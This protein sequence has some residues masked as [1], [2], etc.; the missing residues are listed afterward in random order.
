MVFKYGAYE[1]NLIYDDLGQVSRD[2]M[3]SF[4]ASV[5]VRGVQ[6]Y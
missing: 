5:R 3:V 1:F 6:L 4:Q 2:V